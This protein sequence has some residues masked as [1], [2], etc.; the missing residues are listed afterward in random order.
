VANLKAQLG[1]VG[2]E[3]DPPLCRMVVGNNLE[4]CLLLVDDLWQSLADKIPPELVVGVPTRDVLFV[5]TTAS[6]K[7][8]VQLLR[9]A[10]KEAHGRETTHALT[11]QLL[12]R[13]GNKWEVFDGPG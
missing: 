8:G 3:G 7:G 2:R 9:E 11:Q 13:R 10:V 5:T 12:V 1:N 6:T 4:A